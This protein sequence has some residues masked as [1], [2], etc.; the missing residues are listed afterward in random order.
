VRRTAGE[1]WAWQR[2]RG[3]FGFALGRLGGGRRRGQ[4]RLVLSEHL[5]LRLAVQQLDELL[6][7]DRLAL[8]QD[9]EVMSSFVRCC[10]RISLAS[11]CASSTMR[12]ISSSISRAISSE[13]ALQA[14]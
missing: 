8:Q 7:L 1:A 4:G 12:R 11:W 13:L 6:A 5:L 14:P 10:S 3:P 2:L 9:P